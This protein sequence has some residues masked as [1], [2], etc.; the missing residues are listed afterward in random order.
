MFLFLFNMFSSFLYLS[1]FVQV[2]ELSSALLLQRLP[3]LGISIIILNMFFIMYITI[4]LFP[5]RV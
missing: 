1:L 2:W 3:R 5:Q 4:L